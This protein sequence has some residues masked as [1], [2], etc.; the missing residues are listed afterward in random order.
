MEVI[1][2][3]D[4]PTLGKAG[5]IVKVREGY[6]RNYLLPTQKAV[7][8]DRRN[9]KEL[10]HHK[11]V[12]AAQQSKI[13]KIAL[14]LKAKLEGHSVTLAKEAGEEDKLFGSVTAL[15]IA[16]ALRIEGHP[17]DK[18]MIHLTEPIRSLGIFEVPVKLKA[19]VTAII[20]VWVVK[21]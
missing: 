6:G 13:E 9:I 1:L 14:E 2:K 16:E 21:K 8:A 19:D 18:R 5:E 3:E 7:L 10:D 12:I 4:I 20:K 17:I 11:K 15:E